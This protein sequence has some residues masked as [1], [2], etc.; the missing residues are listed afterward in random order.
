MLHNLGFDDS[1]PEQA[2]KI[3]SAEDEI[4]RQFGYGAVYNTSKRI[5]NPSTA[6]GAGI[7]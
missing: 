1:T 4:L 7:E 3:H 5:S 6:L 2:E